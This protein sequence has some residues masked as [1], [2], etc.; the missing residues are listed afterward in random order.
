[1]KIA[2]KVL[3]GYFFDSHCIR[4]TYMFNKA[5]YLLTYLLTYLANFD[6]FTCIIKIC[7]LFK[8]FTLRTCNN[9]RKTMVFTLQE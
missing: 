5:V 4:L 9:M 1:M 3:G 8:K 6:A 7:C 2:Q